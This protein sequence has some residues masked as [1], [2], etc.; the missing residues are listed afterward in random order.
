MSKQW[1]FILAGASGAGKSTLIAAL[2]D[3]GGKVG[4]T[5]SFVF[6]DRFIDVPGEYL[7]HPSK[8]GQFFGSLPRAK[9]ILFV[10][11][12]NALPSPLPS[13]FFT[14]LPL[15]SYGVI[16]KIDLPNANIEYAK[17]ELLR[18][19][20]QEPFFHVNKNDSASYE[21]LTAFIAQ[22]DA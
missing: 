14:H 5:Q 21:T 13:A 18:L 12:A 11:A 8:R 16:S 6:H 20:L 7:T 15:Q 9:A 3:V 4:K 1:D 19:G 22:D 10:L 17:R 2:N